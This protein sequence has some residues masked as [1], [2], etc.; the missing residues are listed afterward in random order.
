MMNP[1]ERATSVANDGKR[2][3]NERRL[4]GKPQSHHRGDFFFARRGVCYR[5]NLN[6]STRTI[7]QRENLA[8]T[9]LADA[10]AKADQLPI[11]KELRRNHR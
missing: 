10:F 8:F 4:L 9:T 7:G 5:V 1:D 11:D 3:S 6:R 2:K